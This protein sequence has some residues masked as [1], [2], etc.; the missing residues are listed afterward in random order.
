MAQQD[1]P[2]KELVA[3]IERAEIRLPEMQRQYVWQST[4]RVAIYEGS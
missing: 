4:R 3:K 1:I 2:I